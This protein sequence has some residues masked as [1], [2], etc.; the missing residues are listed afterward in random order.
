MKP[1]LLSA[2]VDEVAYECPPE[3]VYA[4]HAVVD[5]APLHEAEALHC[6]RLVYA[7]EPEQVEPVDLLWGTRGATVHYGEDLVVANAALD[8]QEQE[9]VKLCL[10]AGDSLVVASHYAACLE[11]PGVG[12]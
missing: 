8:E 6:A 2:V 3:G 11:V 4:G 9:Q 10:C 12:K 5:A 7:Q 1:S